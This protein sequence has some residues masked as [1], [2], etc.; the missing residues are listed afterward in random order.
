ML[1]AVG[2]LTRKRV[3]PQSPGP[4]HGGRSPEQSARNRLSRMRHRP[5]YMA[6]S[7]ADDEISRRPAND[8]PDRGKGQTSRLPRS[9][10]SPPSGGQGYVGPVRRTF[11][12]RPQRTAGVFSVTSFKSSFPRRRVSRT[13]AVLKA[14]EASDASG[15]QKF[16]SPRWEK[17]Q[18]EGGLPG[19][20]C[21]RTRWPPRRS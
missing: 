21:S 16:P 13:R 20:D 3:R 6:R 11:F 14:F 7:K 15:S 4:I 2:N 1:A 18:D 12:V 19:K 5:V 17:A 10:C 8:V 9:R